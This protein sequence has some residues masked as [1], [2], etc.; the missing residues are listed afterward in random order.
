MWCWKLEEGGRSVHH[1]FYPNSEDKYFPN[2]FIKPNGL[3]FSKYLAMI[4]QI[5]DH[6]PNIPHTFTW[7]FT[8]EIFAWFTKT[9]PPCSHQLSQEPCPTQSGCCS[10]SS[11]L[12]PLLLI[13]TQRDL[14]LPYSLSPSSCGPVPTYFNSANLSYAF[15]CVSQ[16]SPFFT[17]RESVLIYFFPFWFLRECQWLDGSQKWVCGLYDPCNWLFFIYR[18]HFSVSCSAKFSFYW[19]L[20]CTF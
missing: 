12:S 1:T 16:I 20:W 19:K 15:T 11:L 6:M 10:P 13:P 9:S 4:S 8:R 2:F 7:G 3:L 18:Y 14:I 5:S 17:D